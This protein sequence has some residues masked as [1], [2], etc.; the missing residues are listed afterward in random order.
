MTGHRTLDTILG[1]ASLTLMLLV[2]TFALITPEDES[3]LPVSWWSE[4]E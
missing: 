4:H 3:G 2:F 1:V